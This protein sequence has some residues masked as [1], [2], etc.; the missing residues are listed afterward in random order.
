MAGFPP[1]I[2]LSAATMLANPAPTLVAIG[3]S[4]ILQSEAGAI[5][6]TLTRLNN[7]VTMT[8]ANHPYMTGQTTKSVL[9]TD[10][11]FNGAF[12]ITRVDA[13]TITFPCPGPNATT[14][15]GFL[16]SPYLQ[17]DSGVITQ[18]KFKMRGAIS[19]LWNAGIDGDGSAGVL[20]RVDRD[21]IAR[22][23]GY[24][25]MMIGVNDT[26]LTPA[27]TF[28]NI[29]D[30]AIKMRNAGIRVI[31]CTITPVSTG[32]GVYSVANN[33]R[34]LEANKL[35]KCWAPWQF[36]IRL[37]DCHGVM[38]DP[39]A[40]TIQARTGWQL[41]GLHTSARGA[42]GIANPII[43]A[44]GND[45]KPFNTLPRS[46]LDNRKAQP[47]GNANSNLWP[48]PT[49]PT[50]GTIAALP[51]GSTGSISGVAPEYFKAEVVGNCAAL[52]SAPAR[53]VLVDG[54]DCGYNCQVI[55]T[56]AGANDGI[57]ISTTGYSGLAATAAIGKAYYLEFAL[58]V[59][60][61]AGSTIT[62]LYAKIT[63]TVD[64]VN[65]NAYIFQP[66]STPIMPTGNIQGVAKSTPFFIT[67]TNL[68]NMYA[69]W[70]MTFSGSGSPVTMSVGCP[71]IHELPAGSLLTF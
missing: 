13:N 33:Q 8:F 39:F 43:A 63:F 60:G 32:A 64:G 1:G 3:D 34:I 21:V 9:W 54:D 71:S 25:V 66:A 50:G 19:L 37:A 18:L 30:A 38:V 20:A 70:Y 56:P 42:D 15:G 62:K 44:F 7:I 10:A 16:H 45:I 12:A 26:A 57:I 58:N 41:D 22:A 4:I 47:A 49:V 36:G 52:V 17:M 35:L 69:N 11:S 55:A 67:G 59:T 24:C 28:A 65:Y 29:R 27:Q 14:T 6:L 5:G 51:A 40:A 53:M 61:V 48:M 46:P 31:V 2:G 68:T 23:P